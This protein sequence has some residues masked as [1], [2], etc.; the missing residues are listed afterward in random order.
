MIPSFSL[1]GHNVPLRALLQLLPP[2]RGDPFRLGFVHNLDPFRSFVTNS[3]G[4][5][6]D[7][8][9]RPF[10]FVFPTRFLDFSEIGKP[11]R[12]LRVL[13]YVWSSGRDCPDNMRSENVGFEVI[14]L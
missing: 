1:R 8:P 14:S 13:D 11:E 4:Y 7:R 5:P 6:V 2:R 10:L 9:I 3:R 12:E